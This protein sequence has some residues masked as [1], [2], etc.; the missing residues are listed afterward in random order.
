VGRRL[1][2]KKSNGTENDRHW[3]DYLHITAPVI[4]TILGF[5]LA[6]QFVD[7]APP[8]HLRMGTG[9]KQGAYYLFARRYQ[10]IL[11]EEGVDLELVE[12]AGSVENITLLEKGLIDVAFVQGGLSGASQ[13]GALYSLGS[14][15][16]EPLWLFLR[17]DVD[18]GKLADLIGKR[19]SVGAE[20][21]GTQALA[22]QLLGDNRIDGANTRLM[23]LN[24]RQSAEALLAGEADAA[25]FVASPKSQVVGRLL[26]SES[27]SLLSFERAEAYTRTHRFLSRVVL[28]A[29]IVNMGLDLPP[30]DKVLLAA[31]ANLVG[32]GNLHP[33]LIDLLI[34]AGGKIH[35]EGGWF[36]R[37]GQFP[38]SDFV[39]FPLSEDARSFYNRGPS[40][41]QRYLPFWA[42]TQLD[43]LKVMLLPLV[44]LM[45]PLFKIMPSLYRW[46]MRSRIYPWYREV[47]AID[48]LAY[49]SEANL[50]ISDAL[51]KLSQ[52]E[53]DVANI[54]VPLSFT[55]E[56]Y[57][58]RLHISMVRERLEN[59]RK[60]P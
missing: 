28:P 2:E 13:S 47:L 14:F 4:I 11:R 35:G 15:Y 45:I 34:Y 41:L 29:G 48:R 55:E 1:S 38:T 51:T 33:A 26:L 58:L 44:A 56:L 5:V 7:P 22:L 43:R 19:I 52:I 37:R 23:P 32:T 39:D 27:V 21:S 10:E 24:D 57:D 50:D 54:R 8:D 53:R 46:R 20:G 59:P 42:A 18:A 25:F 31:T 60:V 49:D 40:F 30:E 17:S 16:Y 3:M 6:Y 36:E 9:Q 12:S